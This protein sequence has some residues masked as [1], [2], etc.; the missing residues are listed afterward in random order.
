ME[1]TSGAW[2]PMP[3]T[4]HEAHGRSPPR[5]HAPPLIPS[6]SSPAPII[7]YS[8]Y[9]VVGGGGQ[10]QR[11]PKNDMRVLL[12]ELERL[13][14][15]MDRQH[16]QIGAA[17]E[18]ET[19]HSLQFK[20]DRCWSLWHGLEQQ[21][22]VV[23]QQ[24]APGLPKLS[25]EK[26]ESVQQRVD[27]VCA[28]YAI[29]IAER[30]E[31]DASD[32][33]IQRIFFARQQREA[34]QQHASKRSFGGDDDDCVVDNFSEHHNHETESESSSDA[35]IAAAVHEPPTTTTRNRQKS[36]FPAAAVAAPS[37]EELQRMQ[38]E[39]VE[40]AISHMASQLKAETARMK[41]TLEQQN[42][43][44]DVMEDAATDNVHQVTNVA[45]DVQDHVQSS[46]NRNIGT[47]TLFF[48]MVGTF[49]F[50]LVMIQMAPKG[51]G[52]VLFCPP[53]PRPDEFC[54]TLPNG[55]TEC[56]RMDDRMPKTDPHQEEAEEYDGRHF[57]DSSDDVDDM[58]YAS[59]L[60]TQE[61]PMDCEMNEHGECIDA[62]DSPYEQV[63]QVVEEETKPDAVDI[64]AQ[65]QALEELQRKRE[66]LLEKQRRREQSR[67]NTDPKSQETQHHEQVRKEGEQGKQEKLTEQ[68]KRVDSSSDDA[69]ME[70]PMFGGF[71]L[72]TEQVV[73]DGKPPRFNRK[74]FTPRDIRNAANTGDFYLLEGYL[75]VKP[76][77]A[78]KADQ[79]GWAAVHLATRRGDLQ[80]ITFLRSIGA[81]FSVQTV[82][83]R[84]ARDIAVL[85]YEEG[86]PVVDAVEF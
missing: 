61:D 13:L 68:K 22:S 31:N 42:K 21:Q 49:F 24:Q 78:N 52:C 16:G 58:E 29:L 84:T 82:D 66:R 46:W 9:E 38:R 10:K 79:N 33:L 19:W 76:E 69:S 43:G 3:P 6:S 1:A 11:L 18:V 14:F 36:R 63:R 72:A 57:G 15:A 81:D 4:M 39:Q 35:G 60:D 50:M 48:T 44:L 25:N 7:R 73:A 51:K 67:L 65:M 40:E 37:V 64:E 75:T 47:W 55:R 70:D 41:V 85:L 28:K 23:M 56:I 2:P 62:V 8:Q 30:K 54:R 12:I 86:H 80:A 20:V 53:Q 27:D 59:T 5:Q 71:K 83:G 26:M 17:A 32:K 74:F 45:K 34:E 77:W